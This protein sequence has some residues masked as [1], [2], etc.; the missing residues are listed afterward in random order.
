MQVILWDFDG[1]LGYRVGTWSQT[2]CD[3]LSTI[4]PS[5]RLSMEAVRPYLQQG[6]PWHTP[7]HARTAPL[8]ADAWWAQLDP[9][10]IAA[11]TGC[12]VDLSSAQRAAQAVRQAYL[13]PAAWRCYDDTLP[14][15]HALTSL[16][17][18]H[19]I[20]S[21]HVP[22]LP[23]LLDH[24]QLTSHC[25]A[26]WCSATTGY[27]KPH[28]QAFRQVIAALP[29]GSTIWMIG[30]TAIADVQGAEAVVL[31]AILVRRA[32]LARYRSPDLAGVLPILQAAHA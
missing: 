6:F 22:E 18:H 11:Y 8:T 20:L 30:D 15:L 4:A 9:L 12:G 13:D 17:W 28:P 24:L 1:T 25:A 7:A 14:T 23:R 27:E 31:P 5:Y 10:F 21:N 19:A 26:I 16:G 32:G 3:V 29:A 2:L